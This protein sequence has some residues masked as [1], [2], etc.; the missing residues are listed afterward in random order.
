MNIKELRSLNK[1]LIKEIS[2]EFGIEEEK[3]PKLV[4]LIAEAVK[5]KLNLHVGRRAFLAGAGGIAAGLLGLGAVSAK[6]TITDKYIELDGEKFYPSSVGPY[7][8]IVYIDGTKVKA[9]DWKGK[10][11]ANGVAGTD[12]A[13][14]I[15][16]TIE[17]GTTPEG[18]GVYRPRGG[19]IY[20]GPHDF[21]LYQTI[22][23]WSNIQLVGS[24]SGHGLVDEGS[25]KIINQQTDGSPAIKLRGQAITLKGFSLKGNTSSGH[26]I[27]TDIINVGACLHV[28]LEDLD[29][30]EHGGSGIHMYSACY[31]WSIIHCRSSK[32]TGSGLLSE[33]DGTY[34]PNTCTILGGNF[35]QNGDSGIKIS[36]GHSFKLFGT[37][38]QLN[39]GYGFYDPNTGANNHI[40]VGVYTENNTLKG[41]KCDGTGNL[42]HGY[43]NDSY[44]LAAS[45]AKLPEWMDT[46]TGTI[47]SQYFVGS[48]YNNYLRGPPTGGGDLQFQAHNGTNYVTVAKLTGG[49]FITTTDTWLSFEKLQVAKGVFPI[50]LGTQTVP[51]GAT[52]LA[53]RFTVPSGKTLNIHMIA[54]LY[55]PDGQISAE[56]YNVTDTLTVA[57]V[58]GFDDTG[59]SVVAGKVVEFR[60][61]NADGV[62]PHDGNYGFLVSFV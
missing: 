13:S 45:N 40:I 27:T 17:Y 50:T 54:E 47:K 57:T 41:I 7:S 48:Q 3:V 8:A 51:A 53:A 10:E 37:S 42:V 25:T 24:G 59:W 49:K 29:I 18:T 46:K 58:D 43:F 6:T 30:Y 22:T 21:N 33:S 35:E 12:D 2:S 16:N 19:I 39:T 14:V 61:I 34:S 1:E 32:N 55:D 52:V 38:L 20:L 28:H 4:D 23:V 26:G 11:I 15:Q 36:A 31:Y 60:V 56:V 5:P 62:N 9:E 44:E